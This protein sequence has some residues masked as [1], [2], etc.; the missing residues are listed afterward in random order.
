MLL[1]LKNVSKFYYGKDTVASGFTKVNLKLDNNEFIAITGES[2]SG[3][4]TLLNV[5]SGLDTY[6]EGEMYI[7]GE[8]TSGY[9]EVDFENYRKKYIGNIFQNFNLVNSYTV[10]QNVE[11]VLLINGYKKRK[12][13]KKILEV[14]EKVDL[15]KY[16]NTKVS[17]LSG[18]QKQRVAIAR[19]LIKE[20]P[21][22]VADEPTGNLDSKTAE[23]II[24]LLHEVSKD[25][26]VIIV[27]H[28]YEQVEKYVT[29]KLT[30]HDG[31]IIEDKK[32]RQNTKIEA[33]NKINQKESNAIFE[34]NKEASTEENKNARSNEGIFNNKQIKENVKEKSNKDI[35]NN[36]QITKKDNSEIFNSDTVDDEITNEQEIQQNPKIEKEA[37]KLSDIPNVQ[38]KKKNI[39]NLNKIRLGIRNTF[40]IKI[41][42]ILLLLVFFFMT[43]AIFGEYASY[44]K[45]EYEAS[46]LGYNNYFRDTSDKR[47]VIQ[48]GDLSEFTAEDYEKIEKLPNID[49]IE[50]NDIL[51]DSDIYLSSDTF[52]IN[53]TAKSID[54]FDPSK[55][56]YGEMPKN[57]N[58]IVIYGA[59]YNYMLASAPEKLI[60]LECAISGNL[61]GQINDY[62]LKI[63][64]I[65]H[66]PED[67]VD[68]RG[69]Y[70]YVSNNTLDL[71]RRYI[72]INSS[73]T[74]TEFNGKIF[75]SSDYSNQY[76]VIP[77]SKVRK[78]YAIVPV[79]FDYMTKYNNARNYPIDITVENMYFTDNL[80]LKISNTYDEY[81]FERLTGISKDLFFSY[82]GAIFVNNE[83]Y[84]ELFNKGIYQSSVFIKDVKEKDIVLQELQNNGFKTLY[85]KDTLQSYSGGTD[86]ITK[87]I[88]VGVLVVV[89][90]ALCLISYF[91]IKIILKSR[92]VYFSTIRI[93]GATRKNAKSLLRI[94][95]FTV[96]NIAYFIVFGIIELIKNNIITNATLQS[97]V[98]Y[99]TPRD[100]VITYL[101]L[102][103][104]SM[105][106]SNRYSKK[107]FKKS[108]MNTYRDEEV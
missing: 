85:V 73:S 40:N 39:S 17:K 106:I 36:N 19:A 42:F 59:S 23:N 30:M 72:N 92:N 50:K 20:T 91:I 102:F 43:A 60:G 53:G 11:L 55:I 6:E 77:N 16:K 18:G 97:L 63:V 35:F 82:D 25:K 108:A 31:K 98:T 83:E 78:G 8:E 95:L 101:I 90:I 28:N 3:K 76:K 54:L 93:L 29:R 5:I 65:A 75:T 100:F 46:N 66:I 37:F 21:I 4:S 105:I 51:L 58:E 44:K 79:S 2:G 96:M 13:K 47:I 24:E 107:L 22:I 14:L 33:D 68:Y 34:N 62:K 69:S 88:T 103:V 7:N 9:T 26:L 27:T 38:N 32:I 1:E 64:G 71:L 104:I 67:E 84:E 57:D 87:V 49:Y 45:Q 61:I 99:L 12:V 10:Y 41:K 48:K 52:G 80:N 74:K 94:E 89:G 70:F 56:V 81:Y 15:L 86:V